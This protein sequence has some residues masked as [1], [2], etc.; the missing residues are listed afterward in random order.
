MSVTFSSDAYDQ[1]LPV[2]EPCLCTQMDPSFSQWFRYGVDAEAAKFAA[3]PECWTCKGSGVEGYV[4]SALPELN[5]ANEN[6]EALI[7]AMG[8]KQDY[9]HGSMTL[10]QARRGIV[11]ARN[12]KFSVPERP[13][14]EGVF[15]G[16]RIIPGGEITRESVLDHVNRFADFV[17]KVA[18]LGAKKIVWY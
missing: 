6:A 8:I 9:Y 12:T 16:A 17:E 14:W 2:M 3:S 1:G 13:A 5:F 11:R 15:G 7:N 10:A 4:R 18:K